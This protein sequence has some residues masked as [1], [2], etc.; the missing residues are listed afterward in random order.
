MPDPVFRAHLRVQTCDRTLDFWRK[1]SPAGGEDLSRWLEPVNRAIRQAWLSAA[2]GTAER[3]TEW[4]VSELSLLAERL[5]HGTLS[6]SD[7]DLLKAR[8]NVGY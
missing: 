3:R 6:R 5:E 1:A 7:F 8:I 2:T 4:L